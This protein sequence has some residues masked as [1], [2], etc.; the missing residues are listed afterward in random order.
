MY[1]IFS[2]QIFTRQLLIWPIWDLFLYHKAILSFVGWISHDARCFCKGHHGGCGSNIYDLLKD[3]YF[4]WLL[5]PHLREALICA[6]NFN[7]NK[8]K[9]VTERFLMFHAMWQTLGWKWLRSSSRTYSRSFYIAY[10][11][12]LE[13]T[14]KVSF[15]LKE[16]VTS[17]SL[18]AFSSSIH[19]YPI[20]GRWK[21][22]WICHVQPYSSVRIMSGSCWK[23]ETKCH[24]NHV[25]SSR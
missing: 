21:H 10:P 25:T 24:V 18:L 22:C 6:S 2:C 17:S 7:N 1:S 12:F 14:A 4:C 23:Q 13:P 15:C 16:H 11:T 3:V 5:M 8:S 9:L 20:A 19:V